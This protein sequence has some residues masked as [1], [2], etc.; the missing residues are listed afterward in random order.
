MLR[1][2]T[3]GMTL[4]NSCLDFRVGGEHR[5]IFLQLAASD[6]NIRNDK[7]TYL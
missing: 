6:Q 2:E 7:Q 3:F 4:V 1:P 5:D